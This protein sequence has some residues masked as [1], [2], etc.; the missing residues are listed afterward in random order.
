M[1]SFNRSKSIPFPDNPKF[2]NV[3]GQGLTL[4]NDQ[5]LRGNFENDQELR[6]NLENV[7]EKTLLKAQPKDLKVGD[8]YLL[9]NN[10]TNE[11]TVA[12][13]KYY[14]YDEYDDLFYTFEDKNGEIEIEANNTTN[15]DDI[16]DSD[17][18]TINE[19]PYS[20]LL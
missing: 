12:S 6:G 4:E 8:T 10:K 15:N 14:S 5:E 17:D 11:K 18:K 19:D 3:E 9:I 13:Y 7:D 2:I 20:P 16:S 1:S